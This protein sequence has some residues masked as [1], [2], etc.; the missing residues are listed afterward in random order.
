M[1]V[2]VFVFIGVEGA[3]VYSRHAKRREDV[4]KA[5]VLGFSSVLV[6]FVLV[7]LVSYGAMA[8]AELAELRQPSVAGV[9]ASV[10]GPWGAA[11]IG[12]GLIVSV[13]GAYLAWAMMAT[14][15]AFVAA[16][17]KDMPRAFARTNRRDV[18]ATA[19]LA[20]SALT[21]LFL[22]TTLFSDDAFA[23]TLELTSALSLIP[24]L[25]AAA[26]AVKL[27]AG[28]KE[29]AAQHG[30]TKDLVIAGL[31]TFYTAFLL[32]AAGLKF[33]LLS[34]LIYGPGTLLFLRSRREQGQ[35]VFRSWERWLFAALVAGAIFAVVALSQRWVTI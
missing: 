12:A 10:V 26:F 34:C 18:P 8:R 19:L 15:V 9:F 6:L 17:N 25:L 3:S 5:T 27:V 16:Q 30:R 21:Q 23:F 2:T 7:T 31:A 20:T 11:F 14:E 32:Y 1:L 4:G 35:Q 29:G 24:Y 13:L 33:L 22:L 28:R